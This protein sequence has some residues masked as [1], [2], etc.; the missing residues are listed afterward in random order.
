MLRLQPTILSLTMVEVEELDQRLKEKRHH[1]QFLNYLTKPGDASAIP[2]FVP[3]VP[4][5]SSA[6]AR[7]KQPQIDQNIRFL[8][9]GNR[10]ESR[11]ST[12]TEP[13][14]SVLAQQNQGATFTLPDRTRTVEG[15]PR[16]N[17]KADHPLELDGQPPS[18]SQQPVLSTPRHNQVAEYHSVDT[19]PSLPTGSPGQSSASTPGIHTDRVPPVDRERTLERGPAYPSRPA[20]YRRLVEP[21]VWPSSPIT[22]DFERLAIV[23]RAVRTLAQLDDADRRHNNPRASMSPSR[24]SSTTVPRHRIR[25]RDSVPGEP[26]TPRRQLSPPPFEIYDDSVP[27]SAQPQTPQNLP[28]AQHQSRLRGSYTVPTRRGT[29]PGFDSLSRLSRR[30]R[31][32][33][34]RIP[35]PPGLQTPGMMGLYGGLENA[36]DVSL[37]ERAIRRSMEHMDGSPGP[38]R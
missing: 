15:Q 33:E 18:P 30:R 35:S 32:R 37:F 26:T 4:P 23:Q 20:T 7:G 36:D 29:S 8:P 14:S 16:P 17:I 10:P 3:S 24:R 22:H 13:S 19:Y 21:T 5:A 27:P 31:E 28:E 25:P 9:P 6:K 2:E 34:E 11:R 1:R 38:S 12:D